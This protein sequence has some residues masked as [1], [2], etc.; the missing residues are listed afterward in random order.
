MDPTPTQLLLLLHSQGGNLCIINCQEC[1]ETKRELENA[2]TNIKKSQ[3]ANEIIHNQLQ[4][5]RF[6]CKR[7]K[8]E[9]YDALEHS[10]NDVKKFLPKIARGS[11]RKEGEASF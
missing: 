8:I 2:I 9:Y 10:H 6:A 7:V 5:T 11:K 1:S 3:N 4:E